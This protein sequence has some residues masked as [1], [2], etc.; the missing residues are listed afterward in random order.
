MS[1]ENTSS[2]AA[3]DTSEQPAVPGK[4]SQKSS[5]A[6]HSLDRKKWRKY[7]SPYK[8]ATPQELIHVFVLISSMGAFFFR[9]P[10][11]Q[12][13]LLGWIAIFCAA[14]GLA[15]HKYQGD[16]SSFTQVPVAILATVMAYMH[17]NTA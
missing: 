14:S 2:A 15:N 1:Q 7:A 17:P 4:Q 16:Y 5:S 8:N 13:K 12:S 10:F 3:D 11:T 6:Y 9:P